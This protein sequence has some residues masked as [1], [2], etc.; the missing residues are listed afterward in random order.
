MTKKT[1]RMT[2]FLSPWGVAEGSPEE[3][4]RSLTL[5]QNDSL[6]V[7]LRRKPKGLMMRFF[8]RLRSLRMTPFL[9]P[10]GVAEGSPEEI[11]RSLTLPQND[12]K[13]GIL[14]W[15]SEWQKK[16]AQNDSLFV[17]LRFFYLS[18]W[19]VAEGSP[20]G[21]LRSANAPFRMTEKGRTEW[22][23]F[24]VTLRRSRRVS[25]GDSSALRAS[26]WQRKDGILHSAYAPLRMTKKGRTEWLPFCHPE[27]FL[28]V[29]LRRKP[30]GLLR[31]FFGTTCLRMTK[32]RGFFTPLTLC[33]EWQK[34]VAQNDP[35]FVTLRRSRRVS[36]GDSSALRASEW[37]KRS[38]RVTLLRTL[39]FIFQYQF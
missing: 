35:F 18:P 30:K 29:T 20:E 8:G 25:W 16:V 21:I 5:P 23:P 32:R 33:S 10:W 19:G 27:V 13:E 26:E 34:K 11:L 31:R 7:T 3:I 28:Y 4:L 22:L 9:S 15:R 1:H 38:H 37:Q 12:K 24:F 6:F 39:Y 14:R 2:P 36:W 17:T